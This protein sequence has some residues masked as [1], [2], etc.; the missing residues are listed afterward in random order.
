M[1]YPTKIFGATKLSKYLEEPGD[2]T[3][4]GKSRTKLNAYFKCTY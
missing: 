4:V 3:N 2:P 1:S